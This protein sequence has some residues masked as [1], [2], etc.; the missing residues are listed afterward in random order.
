MYVPKEFYKFL[1]FDCIGLSLE[2]LRANGYVI[3][4]M[5]STPD[6]LSVIIRFLTHIPNHR[7]KMHVV[8]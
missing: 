4:G 2:M 8:K 3:F 6:A 5:N 7:E 1:L